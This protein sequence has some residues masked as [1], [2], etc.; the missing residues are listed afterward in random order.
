MRAANT[1]PVR[2]ESLSQRERRRAYVLAAARATLSVVIIGG[3]YFVVPF[4]GYSADAAAFTRL[5]VGIV[6]FV[7]VMYGQVKRIGRSRLP[8]LD[9]AQSVVIAV[10]IFLCTYASCYLTLSRLRPGSF[11]QHLD[12]VGSL[13]FTVTTFGTVGYGDI[14]AKSELARLLVSSQ[15]LLDLV[16][17]A[18]ILRVIFGVSRHALSA[19]SSKT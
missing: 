19:G 18:V 10:A 12:R 14:A 13:Y 4:H 6:V 17:V 2:V 11:S 15:I 5:A 7:A 8:Q 9:A 1:T 16:F 3:L